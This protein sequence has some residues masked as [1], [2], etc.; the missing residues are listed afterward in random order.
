MYRLVRD[1]IGQHLH[2]VGL[3]RAA[4][5]TGPIEK[6]MG[7]VCVLELREGFS[8]FGAPTPEALDYCVEG[9]V[10]ELESPF[11]L[12]ELLIVVPEE[13]RERL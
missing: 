9:V 4:I 6:L 12:D 1:C 7:V 8:T 10:K 3:R 5:Y 13:M 11:S 2:R